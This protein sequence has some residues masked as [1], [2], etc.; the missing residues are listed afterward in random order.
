MSRGFFR[1]RSCWLRQAAVAT[2]GL[3]VLACGSGSPTSPSPNEPNRPAQ[4]S[5]DFERP[6]GPPGP[7]WAWQAGLGAPTIRSGRLGSV[8]NSL[9]IAWWATDTFV[10]DQFSEATVAPGFDSVATFALQVFVRRQGTGVPYRYGFHYNPRTRLYELKYDGGS[11]GIV[12]AS[13][14]GQQ[15]RTGDV[16]RIEIAGTAL[17]GLVNGT[18]VLTAAHDALKSGQAGLVINSSTTSFYAWES[19]RGGS[20]SAVP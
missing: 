1:Q 6:D 17:R 3:A 18:V 19:W 13:V 8:N 11:P 4:R 12:I 14:G 20:L 15:F 7:N 10:D 2:V 9:V 16:V 5:D